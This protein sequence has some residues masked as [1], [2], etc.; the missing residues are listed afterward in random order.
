MTF[1][2]WFD[3]DPG[4]VVANASGVSLCLYV[5]YSVFFVFVFILSTISPLTTGLKALL[6]PFDCTNTVQLSNY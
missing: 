5:C 3:P 6:D 2:G 4:S 1:D